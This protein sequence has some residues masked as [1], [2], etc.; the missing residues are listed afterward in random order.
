MHTSRFTVLASVLT[1]GLI[2]G[3]GSSSKRSSTAQPAAAT[4]HSSSSAAA[5]GSGTASPAPLITTKHAK[6]GTVLAYGPRHLT[7]YMFERDSGSR[8]TCTGQCAEAW[9]PVTGKPRAQGGAI[10]ADLGTIK[11]PGGT[12]Q[13][14]YES[15]PLYGFIKDM[16][17]EDAFGQGSTAFGGG[18]YVL[19][20]SGD[21]IDSGSSSGSGGD[22][23]SSTSTSSSSSAAGSPYSSNGY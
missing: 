7:A 8:S 20:P 2:A 13:V 21:K 10:A 11:R 9:P 19:A 4:V 17:G 22:N 6:V 1:A 18:W 14:T 23:S 12:L 15:H 5:G 16:D 3:C